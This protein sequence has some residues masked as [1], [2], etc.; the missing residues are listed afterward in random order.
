M[1]LQLLVSIIASALAVNAGS[2]KSKTVCTTHYCPK[3]RAHVPTTTTHA[4]RTRTSTV[5]SVSTV[6]QTITPAPSTSTLVTTSTQ[7]SIV[8][9]ESTETATETDTVTATSTIT[10]TS[11]TTSTITCKNF[12]CHHS[13]LRVAERKTS[14]HHNYSY[15]TNYNDRGDASW[16]H[17]SLFSV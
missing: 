15:Y 4:Q 8:D 1:R 16:L 3:S 7:T 6:T 9:T 12:A 14:F 5:Y 11:T 17:A 2:L 10:T 13:L